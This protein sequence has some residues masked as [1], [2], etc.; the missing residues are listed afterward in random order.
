[1]P[2]FPLT[3]KSQGEKLWSGNFIFLLKVKVRGTLKKYIAIYLVLFLSIIENV[4]MPH[5]YDGI[6]HFELVH[7]S[8]QVEI[9][10]VLFSNVTLAS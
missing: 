4:V 10:F 2:G 7:V 1:M 6:H 8:S 9:Y 3:W 5:G